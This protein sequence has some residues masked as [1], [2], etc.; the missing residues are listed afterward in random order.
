MSTNHRGPAASE[1]ILGLMTTLVDLPELSKRAGEPIPVLIRVVSSDEF[2][3]TTDALPTAMMN[4]EE[5]E[6]YM[7]GLDTR[8]RSEL[9]RK[10]VEADCK[11]IMRAVV[12]P[13]VVEDGA[14]ELGP[15]TIPMSALMPDRFH[16][17]LRIM[18]FSGLMGSPDRDAGSK[19]GRKARKG[20]GVPRESFRGGGPDPDRHGEAVEPAAQRD[21]QQAGG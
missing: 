11:M 6:Q 1:K 9:N 19:E 14:A 16:L 18:E 20:A 8:G 12:S 4:R 5:A 21:P 10:S 15:N 17:V 7:A 3:Q 13:R 2:L